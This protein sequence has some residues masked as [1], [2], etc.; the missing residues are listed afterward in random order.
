MLQYYGNNYDQIL[1]AKVIYV[2]QSMVILLN[3]P[4]ILIKGPN[5]ANEHDIQRVKKSVR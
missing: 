3:I 1:K 4:I 2:E 5:H